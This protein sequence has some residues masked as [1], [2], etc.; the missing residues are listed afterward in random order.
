MVEYVRSL[1][2]Q[3]Y[4]GDICFIFI[5]SLI[6]CIFKKSR[7][8]G[9]MTLVVFI[10]LSFPLMNSM[11]MTLCFPSTSHT[12]IQGEILP[13]FSHAEGLYHLLSGT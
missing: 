8:I 5:I 13:A 1:V 3:H 9:P 4:G 6:T 10:L 2:T 12:Y 7:L 11:L